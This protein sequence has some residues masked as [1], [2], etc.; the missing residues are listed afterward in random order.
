MFISVWGVLSPILYHF[1]TIIWPN[2]AQLFQYQQ[3]LFH[4]RQLNFSV[5]EGSAIDLISFLNRFS[6][7]ETTYMYL[8]YL[9]LQILQL[10]V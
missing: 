1:E 4:F 10:A 9:L 5:Q 3:T 6:E 2:V 7:R 8:S